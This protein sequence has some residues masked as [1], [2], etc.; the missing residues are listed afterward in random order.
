MFSDHNEIKS[1]INKIS[2]NRDDITIDSPD[3]KRVMKMSW[4]V[5]NDET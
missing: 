5:E 2:N 1:E 4:V 3:M